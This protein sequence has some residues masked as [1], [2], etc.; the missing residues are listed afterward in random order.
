MASER[1][2]SIIRKPHI[3]I[4]SP[5]RRI[6]CIVSVLMMGAYRLLDAKPMPRQF[7]GESYM[8]QSLPGTYVEPSGYS[9]SHSAQYFTLRLAGQR[10]CEVER[11]F[12]AGRPFASGNA[13]A[14][15]AAN[16]SMFF[17]VLTN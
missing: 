8:G 2:P 17:L 5:V 4:R 15:I 16:L 10:M 7:Q 11:C 9:N 12:R 1:Y 14:S 13:S 3:G 6:T